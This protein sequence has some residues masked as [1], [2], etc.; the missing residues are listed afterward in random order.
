MR[1][2][3][4]WRLVWPSVLQV[5]HTLFAA[6][7]RRR[8]TTCIPARTGIPYENHIM[9]FGELMAARG[10]EGASP[11]VPLGQLPTLTLPNGQVVTQSGA[12]A[13]FAAKKSGL[14]PRDDDENALLQVRATRAPCRPCASSAA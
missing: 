11:A 8:L 4:R 9:T 3:A 10:I 5:R 7:F 14:Y 2:A 6:A 12:H 13:R 1:R